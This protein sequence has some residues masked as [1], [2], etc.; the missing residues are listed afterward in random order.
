ML[1]LGLF[2]KFK[3]MPPIV[4]YAMTLAIGI[5]LLFGFPISQIK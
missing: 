1:V 3:S 2:L 5:T 4:Y